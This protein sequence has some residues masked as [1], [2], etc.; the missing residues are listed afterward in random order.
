MTETTKK[1]QSIK[2]RIEEAD[3][4][5]IEMIE[6]MKN[7]QSQAMQREKLLE[8]G[9]MQEKIE[10][11]QKQMEY[12]DELE[13]LQKK[14]LKI[15][16]TLEDYQNFN[17]QIFMDRRL[18]FPIC[19]R[20]SSFASL[21]KEM[22]SHQFFIHYFKNILFPW[23][24][25]CVT[26]KESLLKSIHHKIMSERN[27]NQE[28]K[29]FWIDP[30]IEIYI[31]EMRKEGEG[32]YMKCESA[33]KIDLI[34]RKNEKDLSEKEDESQNQQPKGA[35]DPPDSFSHL[36]ERIARPSQSI[37]ASS[38]EPSRFPGSFT[39]KTVNTCSSFFNFSEYS[40]VPSLF[41]FYQTLSSDSHLSSPLFRGKTHDSSR[42]LECDFLNHIKEVQ[43]RSI[44][45]LRERK[46]HIGNLKRIKMEWE[47]TGKKLRQRMSIEGHLIP[48]E[49]KKTQK[50]ECQKENDCMEDDD[51]ENPVVYQMTI[52]SP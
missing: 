44:K 8:E 5:H 43:K 49:E 40:I 28:K 9:K 32:Y 52:E 1:K 46:E 18:C 42:L 20:L 37:I 50:F 22:I 39:L 47:K 41:V 19:S 33:L 13:Y 11:L 15:W 45:N 10:S 17:V 7:M 30:K 35:A 2:E 16:D 23:F 3:R 38:I 4:R 24:D 29:E 31:V 12:I 27:N 21:V 6:K 26:E 51:D 14:F 34:H 36:K 25:F 48:K